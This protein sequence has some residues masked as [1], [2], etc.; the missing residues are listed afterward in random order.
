[1]PPPFRKE[2]EDL[3]SAGLRR[4]LVNVESARPGRIT[5]GG[6]ELLNFSSN[7]Y[8]SLSFDQRL[9]DAASRA[10]LE[11][12]AGSGASRLIT[13][14]LSCH[15]SL[16][17]RLS[18]FKK[19]ESALVFNS[20]YHASVG[21]IPA[22]VGRGDEIFSDKLNH[23]SILDGCILSRARLRR[24]PHRDVA[25]LKRLLSRS[26]VKRKLIVTDGVFS[27]D[28]TIAPLAEILDLSR[29]FN[30]LVYVDDAHSTGVL[31][32]GGRGTLEHF[33]IEDSRIIQMGTLGKAL[34]SFGAYVAGTHDIIERL[35]NSARSFIYTTA[36]PP[37]VC[38]SAE[39]AIGIVEKEPKRRERLLKHAEF[40]RHEFL[41]MG[42]DVMGSET[43][44]IPVLI[45]DARKAVALSRALMDKGFYVH[46]VRP[47]TVP[48]GT[49]RLR[50]TP[51][52]AHTE[53]DLRA[54]VAAIREET[55]E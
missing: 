6:R 29:R 21:A 3:E 1:M 23:A 54:L 4:A 7:D 18:E 11:L 25:S 8:L 5:A 39:A 22:L 46:A 9:K 20:G 10:A 51:V 15:V 13:G 52:A 31:G 44:I 2:L 45:G 30:A 38:A 41:S 40:L 55:N 47:P 26:T 14:N 19:T 42:L 53:E 36:L 33:G 43:Q 12:G 27:M 50:V 24:Y 32:P 48:A 34:G 49:S 16:E 28:G 37:S 17:A 35:K